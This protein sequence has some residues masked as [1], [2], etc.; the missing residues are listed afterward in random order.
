ISARYSAPL[1]AASDTRRLGLADQAQAHGKGIA[2]SLALLG[3][4]A[5]LVLADRSGGFLVRPEQRKPFLHPILEVC[6]NIAGAVARDPSELRQGE[7]GVG[8][9]AAR[10]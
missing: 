9:L 7:H 2:E 5:L 3:R 6:V 1:K 10:G 8:R 4:L